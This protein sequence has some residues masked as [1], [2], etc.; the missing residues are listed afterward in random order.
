MPEIGD[1]LEARFV[2]EYQ[3]GRQASYNIRHYRVSAKVGNGATMQEL[4]TLLSGSFHQ[5]FKAVMSSSARFVGVGVRRIQP[6]PVTVESSDAANVGAGG[7]T[8]EILPTQVCGIITLRTQYAGPRYRG[9]VYVP[10]PSEA[11]NDTTG[12]P[13]AAYNAAMVNLANVFAMT[14]TGGGAGN[15]NTIKPVIWSRKFGEPE[16]VVRADQR[17]KWATQRSRGMSGRKNVPPF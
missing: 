2:C 5:T 16:D 9:R 14:L 13:I 8:G 12:E 3:T 1:I 15:T 11:S 17:S 7:V 10:F 4:A 6:L